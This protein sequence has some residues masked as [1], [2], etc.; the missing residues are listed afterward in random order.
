MTAPDYPLL[1]MGSYETYQLAHIATYIAERLARHRASRRGREGRA[2]RASAVRDLAAAATALDAAVGATVPTA[3]G[4]LP[5]PLDMAA[6]STARGLISSGPRSA[7]VVSMAGAGGES[8]AV[9]G[10]VPGIGP[11]GA[12]VGT[13]ELADALR[14]HMLTRPAAEL[15]PWAVNEERVTV[16]TLPR[17]VDLAAFVEHLDP[18]QADDRAIARALRGVNRRTDAAI[19]GR[20]RGIDL[21]APPIVQPPAPAQPTA[22]APVPRPTRSAARSAP[23]RSTRLWGIQKPAA[24]P[25]VPNTSAGP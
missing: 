2:T 7:D 24:A 14:V 13:R 6:Y 23:R 22:S 25:T 3:V 17:Q 12:A 15:T 8:W 20:F 21:D 4:Q 9:V 1:T 11:V 19:R 18:D 5:R 10:Q 16:P